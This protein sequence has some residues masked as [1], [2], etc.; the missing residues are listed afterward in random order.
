MDMAPCFCGDVSGCLQPLWL[1]PKIQQQ[2]HSVCV[3]FQPPPAHADA[4][5][6]VTASMTAATMAV[7]RNVFIVLNL[8]KLLTRPPRWTGTRTGRN[9]ARSKPTVPPCWFARNP[10]RKEQ[11]HE[12]NAV[13]SAGHVSG[14]LLPFLWKRDCRPRQPSPRLRR[15]QQSRWPK[16]A[17]S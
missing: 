15:A 5:D 9:A 14:P 8:I 12:G 17:D 1:F 16:V 11:H 13:N 4:E 2:S 3:I 7:F 10:A 6:V